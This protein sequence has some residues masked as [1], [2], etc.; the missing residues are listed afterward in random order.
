M[1]LL[2]NNFPDDLLELIRNAAQNRSHSANS[3]AGGADSLP[4]WVP[5]QQQRLPL[6]F[7]GPILTPDINASPSSP[8]GAAFPLPGS[9]D[10]SADAGLS[11]LRGDGSA[12]PLRARPPAP[13][14][15][16]LTAQALRMKGVSEA[17]IAAAI[18]NPELMK[19]LII[20]HF[21]PGSAG[22]AARTEYTPHGSI[23]DGGSFGDSRQRVYPETS[24]LDDTRARRDAPAW[25]RFMPGNPTGLSAG[26]INLF[27]A[28]ANNPVRLNG[29]SGLSF[30][31][32]LGASRSPGPVQPL[33]VGLECQG[34]P[35]GCQN[36]G[37][38][39]DNANYYAGRRDL[40]RDCAIR[41]LGLQDEPAI[42]KIETL[43][44]YEKQ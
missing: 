24:G 13:P 41:Y 28:D 44:R 18:G 6:S 1:G 25:G 10:A 39:G 17:D 4:S 20:Q 42:I 26:D 3:G 32:G 22:A 34:F 8:P 21:G 23:A 15:Q 14:A 16:N 38:F 12:D 29:P 2:N 33:P 30:G 19:Q 5:R 40:C 9:A 31:P 37:N 27:R 11:W 7:A 35:A 36:G 43:R